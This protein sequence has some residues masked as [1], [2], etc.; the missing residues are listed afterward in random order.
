MQVEDER[1]QGEQYK[2]QVPSVIIL[3]LFLLL[4]A[5][6]ML[7]ARNQWSNVVRLVKFPRV[8][9]PPG[10][11][12]QYPHEAAQEAAGG[13]RGRVPESHGCTP[14]TAAGAGRGHGDR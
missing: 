14:E 7:A 4:L 5:G 13:V 10:R 3:L 1:K 2:D 6:L 9:L 11:E 12:V 8:S